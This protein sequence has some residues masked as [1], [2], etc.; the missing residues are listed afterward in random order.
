MEER[1]AFAGDN[2]TSDAFD[3]STESYISRK[4]ELEASDVT[5]DPVRMY[6]RE[7]G[8][9]RLLTRDDERVLARKIE[10]CKHTEELEGQLAP[11]EDTPPNAWACV[12]ELLMRL[13]DAESLVKAICQ[14][15][16]M[17]DRVTLQDITSSSCFREILDGQIPEKL[18]GIA[19]NGSGKDSGVVADDIASLSLDTRL[20]PNDVF[21]IFGDHSPL[22][23]LRPALQTPGVVKQLKSYELAYR[24]HFQRTKS[25]GKGAQRHM[26]EANLRLVVS[27]ARKYQNRGMP[28]LDLIQEGNI[29]VM[30]AVE[31][32]DYRRGYKFSTYATWWIQQAV[33]RS[34]ADQSRTIRVPI[35]MTEVINKLQTVTRQL[36]Q[37][38]GREPTNDEIA[39]GMD[40]AVEK[41]EEVLK[42]ARSQVTVSFSTP[43]GDDQTNLGDFIEDPNAEAPADVASI[44]MLKDQ[45]RDV[46]AALSEREAEVLNLRF[47]LQDGRNRTLEEISRDFGVSRE[48]VRQIESK[49][50]RKL[51]RSHKS[52]ALREFVH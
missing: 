9:F 48:R 29:G 40:M 50:L 51:R 46:L 5:D 8:K 32:F 14:Y 36:V 43:I 47:G 12:F 1:H 38:Q 27:I 11:D 45:V 19:A 3:S 25:E 28:L 41:V 21:E 24:A 34:I 52:A 30:R 33:T 26:A 7:I 15:A 42:F 18:V 49:A 22:C 20:L 10:A 13:C 4:Q 17:D 37:Q 35:H 23:E 2:N 39:Q 44:E 16:A 6:L 31:R